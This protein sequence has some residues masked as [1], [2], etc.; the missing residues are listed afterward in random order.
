MAAKAIKKIENFLQIIGGSS[1]LNGGGHVSHVL[2]EFEIAEF[3]FEHCY[4]QL[5]P[6]DESDDAVPNLEAVSVDQLSRQLAVT[7][8]SCN[9]W[10]GNEP[11]STKAEREWIKLL[12]ERY[13]LSDIRSRLI[14][15]T[16]WG[17]L[18]VVVKDRKAAL[19][20]EISWAVD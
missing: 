17:E 3:S 19:F 16:G 6:G 20:V 2:E 10:P 9:G 13:D 14:D 1:P 7:F 12:E 11:K 5:H 15:E 8:W 18:I 4:R